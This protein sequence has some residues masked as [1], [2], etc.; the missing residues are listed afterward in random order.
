LILLSVVIRCIT[1]ESAR[2]HLSIG[3]VEA[4]TKVTRIMARINGRQLPEN[5]KQMIQSV[6]EEECK[7]K[8]GKKA[9]II[10]LFKTPRLRRNTCIVYSIW[11][12]CVFANYAVRLNIGTLI[13][14]NIY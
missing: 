3:Q 6:A 11:F 2:W 1:P 5:Y 12:A 14:G 7:H 13:P 9:T 8:G 4:A 10:D